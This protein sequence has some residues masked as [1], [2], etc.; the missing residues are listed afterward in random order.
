MQTAIDSFQKKVFLALLY[1]SGFGGYISDLAHQTSHTLMFAAFD[2]LMV[3]LGL[4]S[5]S[6]LRSGL[7]YILLFTVTCMFV[8]FS[9][10]DVSFFTS[11]NGSREIFIVLAMVLF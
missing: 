11:L 4:M 3:L 5:F 6:K 8:N 7:G 9:Y 10:S 2:A 1:L